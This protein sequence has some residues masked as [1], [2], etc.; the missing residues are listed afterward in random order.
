MHVQSV[1]VPC[2]GNLRDFVDLLNTF[3]EI[4]NSQPAQYIT[5]KKKKKK[6]IELIWD[7]SQDLYSKFGGD[8]CQIAGVV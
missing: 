8:W 5:F 6:K 7:T 3:R 2:W 1:N 4:E